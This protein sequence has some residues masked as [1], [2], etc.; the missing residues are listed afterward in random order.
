MHSRLRT[1]LTSII[2]TGA[3]LITTGC[4]TNDPEDDWSDIA[5]VRISP[6]SVAISPGETVDFSFT[7][8]SETGEPLDVDLNTR[9]ESTDTSVFSVEDNGLAT[10]KASGS[11]KCVIEVSSYPIEKSGLGDT[12]HDDAASKAGLMGFVGQDSA[13]V[14]V[15]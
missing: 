8:L 3:L 5:E 2:V 9:W 11:A 12:Q 14:V 4:D 15:F 7:L 13:R 1:L 10:A 6:D